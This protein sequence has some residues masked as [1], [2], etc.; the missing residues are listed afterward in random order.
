MISVKVTE[1]GGAEVQAMF[2]SA[3]SLLRAKVQEELDEIGKDIVLTARG[4]VP[5]RTG[6]TMRRIVYRHGRETRHHS[7]RC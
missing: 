3:Q 7:A 4:M 5:R 6:R 2:A 1:L